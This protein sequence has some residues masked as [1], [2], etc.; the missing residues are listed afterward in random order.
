[1]SK[2]YHFHEKNFLGNH[3]CTTSHDI[4]SDISSLTISRVC[5]YQNIQN[6][7]TNAN[8][9]HAVALSGN[10]GIGVKREA[11]GDR[12]YTENKELSWCPLCRRWRH[13]RL[14]SATTNLASWR[15]SVFSV[16]TVCV[17][18]NVD[19]K[20]P[21]GYAARCRLPISIMSFAQW[22]FIPN[23]K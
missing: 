12:L 2:Y 18:R 8:S 6:H 19:S 3:K 20:P 15:L 13:I 22:S 7:D 5:H 16:Q 10:I 1:M 17:E 14:S 4:I 11:L 23:L 9:P 21:S